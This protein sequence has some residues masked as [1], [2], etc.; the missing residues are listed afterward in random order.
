MPPKPKK[1]EG[2]KNMLRSR[3]TLEVFNP[4]YVPPRIVFSYSCSYILVSSLVGFNEFTE[5]H[6]LG[7]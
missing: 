4:P 7:D 6:P 3:F 2:D 1:K 5:D